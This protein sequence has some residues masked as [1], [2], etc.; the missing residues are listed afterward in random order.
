MILAL[1]QEKRWRVY[2]LAIWGEFA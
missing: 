2:G 1:F